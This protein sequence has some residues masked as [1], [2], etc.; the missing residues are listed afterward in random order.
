MK[1]EITGSI[2][3][4]LDLLLPPLI[5]NSF[6]FKKIFKN[7]N[8]KSEII[9]QDISQIKKYYKPSNN[10]GISLERETD[11]TKKAL[12]LIIS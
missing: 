6:I 11:L 12:N 4:Y 9:S 10:M 2:L 7:E 5:R 8:F 3:Y 1:R